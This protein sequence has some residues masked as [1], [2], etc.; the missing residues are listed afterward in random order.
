MSSLRAFA[1]TDAMVTY[2][3][4]GFI[5]FFWAALQA[6]Q[7]L[8][9][10][11]DFLMVVMAIRLAYRAQGVAEGLRLLV[12][13]FESYWLW[14]IWILVIGAGF[15]FGAPVLP[16]VAAGQLWEYRWFFSFLCYI[17]LFK[18]IQWTENH[19]KGLT[20]VL[21]AFCLI[22]FVLYI[23][24]FEKDARAGGIVMH[25]MPF[26]H[27]MGP[28]ALFLLFSGIDKVRDPREGWL[29]RGLYFLTP[30]LAS[31]LV[32]LSM[33]RGIWLGFMAGFF[34]GLIFMGKRLFLISSLA[35]VGSLAVLFLGFGQFQN[36]ILSQT[37]SAAQSNNERIHF[38]KA[39]FAIFKD[40]PIFGIGYGQNNVHV[41]EYLKKEGLNELWSTHAHNQYL[42]FLAGTGILGLFCFLYFL[43]EV[44]LAGWR[45]LR[46]SSQPKKAPYFLQV[47]ALAG[48]LCFCVGSLTES[49][50]SI[51]KNR[52]VFLFLAAFVVSLG[53]TKDRV[54]R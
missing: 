1:E 37:N 36:R 39:N 26:A 44:F 28:T 13:G 12:Q 53:K 46:Q 2:G 35:L 19:K 31:I 42:H 14:P 34:V 21:L 4:F 11:A 25:A 10:L 18:Q 8:M 30:V 15:I 41:Q 24:N 40:Y 51:A 48:L 3:V 22:D 43:K 54:S 7:S 27:T 33:T 5:L 29:W 49:N 17:Y 38:W 50:F 45:E 6:T 9:D 47:G 20:L 32:V 52:F 16:K 23:V